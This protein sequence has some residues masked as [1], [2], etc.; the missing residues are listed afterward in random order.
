MA[1]ELDL[2][3]STNLAERRGLLEK[4]GGDAALPAAPAT[5]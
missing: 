1:L 2:N 5:R 4:F 3:A